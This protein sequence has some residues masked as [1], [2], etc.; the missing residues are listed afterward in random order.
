MYATR[1]LADPGETYRQVDINS[2]INGASP[3]GLICLLFDDLLRSLRLGALATEQRDHPA[4]SANL[5]KALALLFALE[6][7]LDFERGGTVAETLSR[8]Y[9]GARETV[10][11]ASL[12]LDAE[13]LR[14]VATNVAEIADSWRA[15]GAR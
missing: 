11:E 2:R 9:R 4:K 5:T 3:H 14:R 7:G 10:M 13:Q 8:F 15:I 1:L 6:S 12:A